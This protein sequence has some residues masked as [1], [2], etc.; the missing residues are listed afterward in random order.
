MEEL[1]VILVERIDLSEGEEISLSDLEMEEYN[2]RVKYEGEKGE[3]LWSGRG[4]F[5]DEIPGVLSP[6]GNNIENIFVCPS[7]SRQLGG[8]L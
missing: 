6:Y 2:L 8:I 3:Y 5:P 7:N 1:K 4:L